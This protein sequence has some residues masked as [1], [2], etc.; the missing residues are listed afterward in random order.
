MRRA[1]SALAI[2]LLAGEVGAADAPAL[3][4]GVFMPPRAAPDFELTATD[5]K[6]LRLA[7]YRGKVVLLGFGFSS[8]PD[9][10]PTTLAVLAQA[11]RRI[12]PRAAEVQV[13]YVTVDPERDDAARLRHYLAA[14]D[15]TFIGGTGAARELAAVRRSYGVVATKKGSGRD[16]SVHHSSSVY[17]I[18]RNGLLR[19]LMPYGRSADDYAHD[20]RI[21]LEEGGR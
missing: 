19:A 20:V 14:F 18:D 21:L 11:R 13:V 9:V 17:L 1:L 10:C 7:R 12:G 15:P 5:G 4:A 2:V 6:P 8:C 16:Y 3:K